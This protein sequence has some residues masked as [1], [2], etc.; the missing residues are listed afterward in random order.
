MC[1]DN[2]FARA[3]PS[4]V[5]WWFP[6]ETSLARW[7]SCALSLRGLTRV[8]RVLV[9][10]AMGQI[11]APSSRF[12]RTRAE[13]NGDSYFRAT[14]RALGGSLI[15][16]YRYAIAYDQRITELDCD[17][18]MAEVRATGAQRGHDATPVRIA[19]CYGAL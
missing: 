9:N 14:D 3:Q 19:T 16:R 10:I 8:R 13:V 12:S 18:V 4:S 17:A 5:T 1:S 2:T 7:M 15:I 11:T 6:S